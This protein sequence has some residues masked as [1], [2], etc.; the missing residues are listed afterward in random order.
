MADITARL[1]W[2][3]LRENYE[4][5][6]QSYEEFSWRRVDILDMLFLGWVLVAFVVVGLVNLYL[7]FFGLPK[8]FQRRR[9]LD[10]RSSDGPGSVANNGSIRSGEPV[11]WINAAVGWIYEN[12]PKRPE[13]I[14][15][16]LKALSAEAKKYTVSESKVVS[17]SVGQSVSKSALDC[18]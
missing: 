3:R 14:E 15:T 4:S 7:R 12:Y 11:Q 16:W 2:Y 1:I 17:Q 13:F 9:G 8:T 10:W 6:A 18:F 5:L